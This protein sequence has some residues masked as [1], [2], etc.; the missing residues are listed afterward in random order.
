VDNR[1]KTLSSLAH[2]FYLEACYGLFWF[3]LIYPTWYPTRWLV[4]FF[5]HDRVTIT[6]HGLA[7]TYTYH[8][9]Q[10]RK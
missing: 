6:P 7:L 5:Q 8:L 3:V 2:T 1:K 9:P 10:K 4:F